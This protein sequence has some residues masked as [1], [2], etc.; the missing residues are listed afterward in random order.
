MAFTVVYNGECDPI[1]LKEV[2]AETLRD[3]MEKNSAVCAGEA[4]IAN[5][6]WAPNTQKMRERYP[7][8]FYDVGIQEADMVGIACGLSAGGKIPY[9]HSFAPFVTRRTYDVIFVSGAYGHLNIRLIGSDPG[10][11]AVYNGGTHMCFEDVGIMRCIPQM[12]IVDITDG[13]MLEDVLR[14]SAGIYG[15]FYLR[16]ARGIKAPAIYGK[17]ST[18]TFGKANV[19]REGSDLTIIASGILV[20]EALIAAEQLKA[21]GISARV[22]DIFTIK[23]IDTEL[24]QKCAAETGAVVTAENHNIIGGLGSAVA[25]VLALKGP[26]CPVE[27]VGVQDE[28]GEVGD[29]KYLVKRFGL[30]AETIQKKALD[31]LKRKK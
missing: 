11:T 19:L 2:Y 28:F 6:M 5:G 7:D 15:M 21:Q 30:N 20:S 13:V 25:E 1:P 3:L 12:T 8:R 17:G 29:M 24:I 27:M 16:F 18:F 31:V 26:F 9:V 10:V 4:D 22:V 23:P 14:Q